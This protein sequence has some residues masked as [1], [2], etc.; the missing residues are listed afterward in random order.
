MS[1]DTGRGK[2]QIFEATRSL[3][4]QSP[5]SGDTGRGSSSRG[6]GG[7][8]FCNPAWVKQFVKVDRRLSKSRAPMGQV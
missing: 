4:F 8:D 5:M 7:L 6:L 2:V 3:R 1:G